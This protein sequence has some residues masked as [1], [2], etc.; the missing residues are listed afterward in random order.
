MLFCILIGKMGNTTLYITLHVYKITE[1]CMRV[2]HLFR[3][4]VSQEGP[5]P[6]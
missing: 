1:L 5:N 3:L 2:T 4:N 6:L